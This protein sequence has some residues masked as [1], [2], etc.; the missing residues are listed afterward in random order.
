MTRTEMY[1][2]DRDSAR[3]DE[4]VTK[5]DLNDDELNEFYYIIIFCCEAKV[6]VF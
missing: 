4:K 6:V 1:T 5:S 2:K 3:T